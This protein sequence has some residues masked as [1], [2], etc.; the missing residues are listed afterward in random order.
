MLVGSA[1]WA[2]PRSQPK[3]PATPRGKEVTEIADASD[4]IAWIKKR[5]VECKALRGRGARRVNL[6]YPAQG[7]G[8]Y[9]RLQTDDH[10]P[11]RYE[12]LA[13]LPHLGGAVDTVKNLP[14]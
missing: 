7:A 4:S 12:A 11:A 1:R 6:R 3:R 10:D 2:F 5:A 13:S 14:V 9:R 8:R